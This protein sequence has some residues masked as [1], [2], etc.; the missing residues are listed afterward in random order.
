MEDFNYDCIGKEV[1][2]K[3]CL[4]NKDICFIFNKFVS[5]IEFICRSKKYFFKLYFVL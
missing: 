4:M 2:I 1:V 5:R 3:D